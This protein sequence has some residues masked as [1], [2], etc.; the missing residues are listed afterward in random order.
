M[1]EF[2]NYSRHRE[3][4]RKH[5]HGREGERERERPLID[6][7][8]SNSESVPNIFTIVLKVYYRYVSFTLG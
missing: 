4:E 8:N 2:L 7:E 1:K 5:K 6:G 3:R